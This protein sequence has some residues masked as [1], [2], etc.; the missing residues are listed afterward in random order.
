M[1]AILSRLKTI[2]NY[3]FID[4][5]DMLRNRILRLLVL[6]TLLTACDSGVG[7]DDE[8]L[9]CVTNV[10]AAQGDSFV[11]LCALDVPVRHVRIENFRAP[12]THASAQ[13]LFGFDT[14]PA[15]ATAELAPDQFRVLFYGGG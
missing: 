13:I 3:F 14:A 9:E 6:P 4:Y 2:L 8:V 12:A 15:S 7:P 11:E 10:T 5:R 1:Y